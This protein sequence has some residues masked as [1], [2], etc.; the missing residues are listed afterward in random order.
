MN[1]IKIAL[2]ILLSGS[3]LSQSLYAQTTAPATRDVEVKMILLDVDEV[4][5]VRQSLS[6]NVGLTM[7][8]QDR[9]LAH[10]GPDAVRLPLTDIWHPGIQILN[11]QKIVT[12]FPQFAEIQP[13]GTIVYRQRYWG[14]FSQNLVLDAFPFDSQT[15]TFTLASIGFGMQSVRLIPAVDSGISKQISMPDWDIVD[16]GFIAVDLPFEE[17]AAQVKGMVFSLDVERDKSYFKYKV[18]LP[19]V[20]IVMMSWMVFWIDPSLAATQISVSVTAMLTMI[21]YRFALSG[22]IPRLSF[23]TSLDLFVLVSTVV[24]FLSMIEVL[25]TAHLATSEQLNKA[26]LVDR[27]A[28]W[29]APLIYF[30]LAADALNFRFLFR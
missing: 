13:D 24:V 4:D 19:L 28:R 25:Y 17:D 7:R 1:V 15:L 6:A 11:Q 3:A 12:T 27:H 9:S 26:R 18:I 21:A 29:V 22:F 16:W 30:V 23:L 20:L 14:S 8:W 5:N 2:V 10:E